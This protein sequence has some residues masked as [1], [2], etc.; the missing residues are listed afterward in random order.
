MKKT[1]LL[2]LAIISCNLLNAQYNLGLVNGNYAGVSG[3]GLQP[4]SVADNRYQFDFNLIS[5]SIDFNN[6][7]L[8]FSRDYFVNNRFSFKDFKNYE[9]FKTRVLVENDL[10]GKKA[11]FN[12]NNRTQLPLSFL[13]STGKKSGIALNIQSRTSVG[14]Q[15]MDADF[16][17]QLYNFWGNGATYG[18]NYNLTG[19][20]LNALNWMEVGLTYG[21][22]LMNEGKHFLKFGVTAKYLGGIS[23]WNLKA[24]NVTLRAENDSSLTG[25]GS[26]QYSHSAS[27]ISTKINS[28]YRPDASS[29]GGDIGV[30]Y[31][32]RGRINKFLVPKYNTKDDYYESRERRDKNKYSAKLGVSLLDV[33]VLNFNSAPLARNFKF[34]V[35]HFNLAQIDVRNI[36]QFDTLI[37]KNVTY[38][39]A[40]GASYSVAMPTALSAQLDIHV[41]KGFYVNGMVYKPF[42]AL[43]KNATYRIK[44]PDFY[45]VTPRWESR[46][47]GVYAPFSINSN[48][49][50]SA[51]AT[52]RVGPLF[53]GTANMLTLI[54]KDNIQYAD[55]HAGLKIPIAHGKPSRAA[56]WFKKVSQNIADTSEVNLIEASPN[57]PLQNSNPPIQIIINNYNSSAEKKS[58]E[59]ILEKDSSGNYQK[60]IIENIN[61][62]SN[63]KELDE[64]EN[65]LQFLKY[66]LQQKEQIIQKLE[67]AT[68]P[69]NSQSESS[70][71]KKK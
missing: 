51:G 21:R 57:R 63:D 11:Y 7:Y 66:K 56:K 43:S 68:S 23:S 1:L 58:S 59:Y 32:F 48:K 37:S 67:E 17:K 30:V 38:T 49:D 4:A 46:F 28:S 41:F 45:A 61:K 8:G 69:Q 44:S 22:V 12:L 29:W 26:M 27:E 62:S 6:N 60:V 64:L 39:N 33:G 16:A 18:K 25:F 2:S 5:T 42:N 13:L 65:E 36:K 15:N 50:I 70:I 52:L 3:I 47:I 10:Q 35:N 9:D 55:I 20:E 54:K 31:E 19:M 71:Q 53:V 40:N 14:I 24:N 34:D